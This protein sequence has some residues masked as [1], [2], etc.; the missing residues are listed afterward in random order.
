MKSLIFFLCLTVALFALSGC[1]YKGII[2]IN[3]PA[4]DGN[5]MQRTIDA[6]AEVSALP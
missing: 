2:Y 4:G 3:S 5:A 6:A 1:A